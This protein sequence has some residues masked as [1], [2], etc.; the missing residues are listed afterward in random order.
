VVI[1]FLPPSSVWRSLQVFIREDRKSRSNDYFSGLILP[2]IS[3]FSI[4]H[5]FLIIIIIIN[6]NNNFGRI[7]RITFSLAYHIIACIFS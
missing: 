5:I 1:L 6:N 4:L 2:C 7:Y 3:C